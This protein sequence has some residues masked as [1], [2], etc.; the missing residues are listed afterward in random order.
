MS[1]FLVLLL[2]GLVCKVSGANLAGQCTKDLNNVAAC[3]SYAT[4]K[5][6]TPSKDCCTSVEGIRN[7]EPECLCY[8]IQQTHNGSTTIKSLG[9]QEARLLQL[10][11]A[12]NLKNASVSNCPKLLGLSPSSPDAAIF[13]NI[14]T[15][16][17]STPTSS[18]SEKVKDSNIG[19]RLGPHLACLMAM[20]I[21]IFLLAFPAGSAT[22]TFDT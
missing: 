18:S 12:C 22:T 6:N 3:L 10:P 1:V 9:I 15:A 16:T 7:T 11:T 19:T 17:P 21:A 8:L 20:V 14:S 13:T 5:G 2:C 4:G